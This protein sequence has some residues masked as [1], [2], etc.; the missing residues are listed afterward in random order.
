MTKLKL[1]VLSALTLGL[2]SAAFAQG[3]GPGGRGQMTP[4]MAEAH[5]QKRAAIIAK[6]DT[7]KDG[8]LDDAERTVMQDQRIEK[9]FAMLD[10]NKDGVITLAEMKAGMK[11][12]GGKHRFGRRGHGPHGRTRTIK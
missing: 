10:T 11:A 12:D 1:V 3:H 4:E 2:S 6:F 8:K 5:A 7:N 9:R